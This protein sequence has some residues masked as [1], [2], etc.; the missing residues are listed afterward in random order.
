MR[1]SHDICYFFGATKS[2]F[3][4]LVAPPKLWPS[5]KLRP[6][7]SYGCHSSYGRL[8]ATTVTQLRPSP[9]LWPFPASAVAQL[10]PS[11][12]NGRHPSYGCPPSHIYANSP[13]YH[14]GASAPNIV[15]ETVP[16]DLLPF[17]VTSPSNYPPHKKLYF[18]GTVT[19]LRKRVL[20][21]TCHGWIG[22]NKI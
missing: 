1:Q 15:K 7:P 6:S 11:S 2:I 5:P 8:P 22:L 3:L 12:S 13:N 16:R 9:K 4:L 20:Y 17:F 14:L 10:R 21:F 19:R 18:K